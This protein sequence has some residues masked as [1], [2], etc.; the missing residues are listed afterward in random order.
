[1]AFWRRLTMDSWDPFSWSF[2]HWRNLFSESKTELFERLKAEKF[3]MLLTQIEF[4][5]PRQLISNILC[6]LTNEPIKVP[7]ISI[8]GTIYEKQAF[9][10]RIL[11]FSSVPGSTLSLTLRD[12][13]SFDQLIGVLDF[14]RQRNEK[15][16]KIE[17]QKIALAKLALKNQVQASKHPAIFICPLSKRLIHS[18]MISPLGR[19]YELEAIKAYFETTKVLKD[20]IDGSPLCFE[21]LEPFHAFKTQLSLYENPM[22]E[23]KM[24]AKALFSKSINALEKGADFINSFFKPAML[25]D[26]EGR[27]M[28]KPGMDYPFPSVMHL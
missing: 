3:E 23:A 14:V 10:K 11:A 9:E 19:V 12:V 26:Q 8:E 6:P 22:A 4:S 24:Q 13:S 20:P 7:I 2:W 1:M 21:S 25:Q 15:Y 16:F 28:P 17:K 5:H 18:P 27:I